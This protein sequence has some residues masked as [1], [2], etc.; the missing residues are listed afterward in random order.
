MVP[1]VPAINSVD[2]INVYQRY[3]LGNRFDLDVAPIYQ[4]QGDLVSQ[5]IWYR[6]YHVRIGSWGIAPN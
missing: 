2:G 1:G 6:A 3:T 5:Y 4:C